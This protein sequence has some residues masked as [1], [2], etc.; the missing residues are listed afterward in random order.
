V[1]RGGHPGRQHLA[2]HL[3]ES[4]QLLQ[5]LDAD[6][7]AYPRLDELQHWQRCRLR[8]TYA[9]L[10]AQPQ[11]ES[12]CV[13]FLEE[14]YGGRDMRQRDQQLERVLPVMA[15]TM[16]D[17]LL[18]AMGD[19]MR[20]QWM[21]MDLDARLSR[22]LE[23][24][25]D[26]AEYARAYRRMAAWEEREEQIELIRELGRLLQ[27]TVRKRM[28]R[29]LVRLMHGPAVAAGFGK[30]Q[31]FL[32]QGLDA[33][34]TMG[35]EAT[36]FIDTIHERETIALERMREGSGRPFADWIGDGPS[37]EARA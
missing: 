8:E 25:L 28:V 19:A 26:Q 13:F 22:H 18:A 35:D 37:V 9:D 6:P 30:L 5:R 36:L 2:R 32:S 1:S 20:L 24:E 29:R 27:R 21:S 33:F 12:A 10:K 23:G 34:A 17:H 16:P 11:F 15:R 7:Q 14:L 4:L 31:E 3:E